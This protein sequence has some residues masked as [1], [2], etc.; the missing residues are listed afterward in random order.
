MLRVRSS[1]GIC[2]GM[3]KIVSIILSGGAGSRLWPVS[4]QK[5][6]K[7]FMEIGGKPLL[8]HA[9]ERAGL[10]SDDVLI[11][12]NQDHHSLTETLLKKINNILNVTYLLEPMG[13]NTA[14]AIALATQYVSQKFGDDTICLVLAADHLISG[15][16]AFKSEV[17]RACG[18]AKAGNLVVFGVRPTAPETGYGYVEV[19]TVADHPQP[20]KSFVEKPDRSTAEKYL[21]EGRYYWNSGMFCF[22]AGVMAANMKRDAEDVWGR[23]KD[24]FN[25]ALDAGS[26]IRFQPEQFILQ[27]DISLDYAV[28]EKAENVSMVPA[29]FVWSDVGSWDAVAD[30]QPSDENGN[31][32]VGDTIQKFIPIDS[33]NNYVDSYSHTQK[34][35]S[36]IGVENLVIIDTP[37]ALLVADRG[38]VQK[39]KQVVEL[40]RDGDFSQLTEL[41]AVVQRPWGTYATL[42]HEM[43]Y[44]VKRVTVARG[45]QLSLQYHHRRSE[46]WIVVQ[47]KALVQTGDDVWETSV[48]DYRYIP[49]GA[50]HRLTNI[51]D[52]ELVLIEVQY[53]DYLG[54]DDIVRLEDDYGRI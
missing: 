17:Q 32:A 42:K 12:T 1:Q 4:R 22:E 30:A 6:P 45:Q 5:C 36:T 2:L 48:N 13:R 50:K 26:V 35:I 51:G 39:V 21:A 9:L 24:A 34:V 18:E 43:N 25:N 38:H 28:M 29:G 14:P 44:Q 16:L 15:E 10:V 7:P 33:Q 49:V 27:P 31:A 54:E 47:G 8:Q 41:Q 37:D 52:D 20:V 23:S 40:L 53:G 19:D 46:H 11:V 3:T